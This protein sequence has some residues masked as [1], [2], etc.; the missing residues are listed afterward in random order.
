MHDASQSFRIVHNISSGSTMGNFHAHDY[1]EICYLLS[2][3]VRVLVEDKVF[4]VGKGD[5]FVFNTAD[6]HKIVVPL[7]VSY[8]R[9]VLLFKPDYLSG[10]STPRTDLFE[11]FH[12][13]TPDF[14]YQIRLLPQQSEKLIT[15][16]EKAKFYYDY[17][18]RGGDVYL[19][20]VLAEIL[21]FIN[22]LYSQNPGNRLT[23]NELEYHKVKPVL[24]YIY[25]HI[26]EDLSLDRLAKKFFFSKYHL[27][28]LFKKATGFTVNE[29][30]ISRRIMKAK[31]LL[32][33][34]YPVALV[35]EMVG[36]NNNSHF[37][38]TF[39]KMVGISPK[40]Y[41]KNQLSV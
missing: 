24:E 31:E 39:K 41:V 12:K 7:D 10:F 37:I 22:E 33:A 2:D 16:F 15:L 30:I 5:L 26:S 28:V 36:F 4:S 6:L 21:L 1:F 18:C 3:G 19:K 35:G 40:K 20:I 23:G 25:Q 11:C 38:R 9:Y 34:A 14:S 8:D 32:M 29:Y 13:R 27:S 17:P